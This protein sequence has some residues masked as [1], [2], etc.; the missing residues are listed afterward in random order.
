MVL[1]ISMSGMKLKCEGKPPVKLGQVIEIKLDSGSQRLPIQAQVV[2]IKRRGFKTFTMGLRFVNIKKSLMAAVES[3]GMFG[4]IDLEAV[5][6]RKKQKYGDPYAAREK[7]RIK[8]SVEFPDYY[9]IL[10][11]QDS[12]TSDDIQKA[13]RSLARIHHPDVSKTDADAQ[14]FLQISEAYEV[15]HDPAKR[16][17]YDALRAA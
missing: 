2:W 14:K 8:A 6:K 17:T 1:D 10:E 12:A 9:A 13:F 5:A 3:L 7:H 15:L 16:K 4:Y 11:V